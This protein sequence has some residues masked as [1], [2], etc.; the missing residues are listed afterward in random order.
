MCLAVDAESEGGK[1]I[2]E[3][4]G[5]RAWP[6]LVFL[7]PDGSLRDR[8]TGFRPPDQLLGEFRRARAGIGTFGEIEKRVAAHPQDVCARLDLVIRLRMMHDERWAQEMATAHEAIA[9]GEGF[10]PKS[11]D[12]RYAVARRLKQCADASGY[13]EQ[14]DEIRALDPEGRSAA[15]HL[16]ALAERFQWVRARQLQDH[17]LDARTMLEYLAEEHDESVLFEGWSALHALARQRFPKEARTYGAEAWKHCPPDQVASLGREL[18]R[19]L[20]AAA[21]EI[22][23]GQ[24]AFAVELATKASAAAPQSVD[25]LETLAE[26]LVLAGRKADAIAV[27]ERARAIEPTRA[28][29]RERIDELRR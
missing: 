20:L 22:D 14:I 13:D 26:C 17:T 1:P 9:R 12:E 8:Q 19:E 16:L 10:D 18:A 15:S 28:S 3:R 5:I 7:E 25:H 27:L 11:P 2:A 23:D 6:A 24:R 4:Y 21:P 29:L